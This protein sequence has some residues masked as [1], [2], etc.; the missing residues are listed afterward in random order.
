MALP[1]FQ[2]DLPTQFDLTE[3]D[4]PAYSLPAISN[5]KNKN[6]TLSILGDN[7]GFLMI[8]SSSISVSKFINNYGSYL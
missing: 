7:V 2:I 3:W 4:S 8:N 6:F 1:H 5:P